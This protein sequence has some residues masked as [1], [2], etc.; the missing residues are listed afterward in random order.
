[1]AVAL[2][3]KPGYPIR[4]HEPLEPTGIQLAVDLEQLGTLT[5]DGDSNRGGQ[6]VEINSGNQSDA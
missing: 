6:S 4:R 1:M 5:A 2:P 3:D